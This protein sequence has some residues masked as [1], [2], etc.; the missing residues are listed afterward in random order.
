[1][2]VELLGRGD[3]ENFYRNII[4]AHKFGLWNFLLDIARI[5]GKI[6]KERMYIYGSYE[7]YV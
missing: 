1:M 7:S 6:R 3:I 5:V 4:I 2:H